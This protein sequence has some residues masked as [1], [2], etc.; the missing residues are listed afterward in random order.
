MKSVT[1]PYSLSSQTGSTAPAGWWLP[2][3]P[4][5]RRSHRPRDSDDVDIRLPTRKLYFGAALFPTSWPS[6]HRSSLPFRFFPPLPA[7]MRIFQHLPHMAANPRSH[8]PSMSGSPNTR[9]AGW[10]P[11]AGLGQ[12]SQ[13][14]TSQEYVAS[15]THR[16]VRVT[17]GAG[18]RGSSSYLKTPLGSACENLDLCLGAGLGV[19]RRIKEPRKHIFAGSDGGRELQR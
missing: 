6:H 17:P 9:V 10:R 8:E 4:L 16:H 7:S 15:A 18:K 5:G 2:N 13:R 14:S 12:N 19:E 1:S 3:V 11:L